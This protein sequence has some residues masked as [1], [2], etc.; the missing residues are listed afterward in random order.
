MGD[1]VR[2]A[3]I[4]QFLQQ[5]DLLGA[6]YRLTQQ[7]PP[8]DMV[9]ELFS[10]AGARHLG[11][12]IL[13]DRSHALLKELHWGIEATQWE[14]NVDRA[15]TEIRDTLAESDV[16]LGETLFGAMVCLRA[17]E[18]LRIPFVFDMHGILHEEAR[19]TGSGEWVAWCSRWERIVVEAADQ[20]VV[21]SPL[22]GDYVRTNYTVRPDR[23]VLA[24][25][26]TYLSER[27]AQWARPQTVVYAGNF[28]G[29]EN[30]IEVVKTA[31]TIGAGRRFWLLGDGP[32]RNEVFDYINGHSVDVLYW[33]R[34]NRNA[35]LALCAQ[36]QIGLSGQ[37][38]ACDLTR[39][40][41]RQ[42]GCPIKLFDYAACGLPIVAPPGEWAPILEDAGCAVIARDATAGALADAVA[43]L[44]DEGLWTRMSRAARSLAERYEW[45]QV[46]EPL[47]RSLGGP[48]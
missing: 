11:R 33:G 35:A 3:A 4:R 2:V 18:H 12:K 1:M 20:V 37:T 8:V 44:D 5:H 48:R 30:I 28:A 22:M 9:R 6:E 14:Q 21:V 27:T 40:Y 38:G 29:F 15:W 46:L 26:G 7:R 23:I 19:L 32:L 25:N 17:K 42:L 16:L 13:V 24:P 47:Q 45:S 43:G 10:V 31:E 41:P 39:D 36:A 34:R